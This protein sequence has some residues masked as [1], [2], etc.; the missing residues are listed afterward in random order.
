RSFILSLCTPIY[1]TA[2]T[3]I[4]YGTHDNL[5]VMLRPPAYSLPFPMPIPNTSYR[6]RARVARERIYRPKLHRT[7]HRS[8]GITS[9][10][11]GRNHDH[12]NG[13]AERTRKAVPGQSS[14][15]QKVPWTFPSADVDIAP[16]V[17]TTAQPPPT[18]WTVSS[19]KQ[20]PT[21][22]SDALG[23]QSH[24][25]GEAIAKIKD[26]IKGYKKVK[27][28]MK[29]EL[30]K[31]GTS[32]ANPMEFIENLGNKIEDEEVERQMADGENPLKYMVKD[33][34]LY[35]K[36]KIP[37][38]RIGFAKSEALRPSPNNLS[39]L[40]RSVKA[41]TMVESSPV[42]SEQA[43]WPTASG[44]STMT[45]LQDGF[46]PPTPL[47][48]PTVKMPRSSLI[49]LEK[50]NEDNDGSASILSRTTATGNF[51]EEAED[52][53]E[54]SNDLIGEQ[55]DPPPYPFSHCYMNVDG[56]MC[57]NRFLESLM[58]KSYRKLR[59]GHHF[60]DCSVQKIAN[61]IQSDS[62]LVFNTTF[63]TVV[64]IDDFAIRAHFA[65]DL[66]CKIQEGGRF[67][68]NYATTMPQ[69]AGVRPDPLTVVTSMEINTRN[70]NQKEQNI[71]D[72]FPIPKQLD[73][74]ILHVQAPDQPRPRINKEDIPFH[75]KS[76]E[77]IENDNLIS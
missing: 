29:K 12:K 45:K 39:K 7:L 47:A 13:S 59:S 27:S 16:T 26:Y 42:I 21:Y 61:R 14:T 68:T 54:F 50:W 49:E 65:G 40:V 70:E 41:Q 30:S 74:A 23:S 76:R 44:L 20:A 58:R 25:I 35:K 67:I 32:H 75:E 9:R 22:L 73:G 63:E 52:E 77:D 3:N 69:R 57:C 1:L 24:A 71:T 46:K 2:T 38:A 36:N 10:I 48:P 33:G 18:A 31:E 6:D 15:T 72:D 28:T 34:I 8:F 43:I 56:F 64:G 11:V 60:H 37:V 53:L 62:E 51:L 17:T 19:S 5:P 55:R 4:N 66:M